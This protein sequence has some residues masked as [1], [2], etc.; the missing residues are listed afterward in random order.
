MAQ[1]IALVRRNYDD[2]PE[3]EFTPELLEAEA[4]RARELYGE[5]VY[6]QMWSRQDSPGAV[7]L[8]EAGSA[9]DARAALDTLPLT[10]KGM[11][12]IDSVIPLTPYRG[13]GPRG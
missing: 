1:F 13:F 5:G 4:E 9:D 8:I 6:R 3:A 7:I 12:L 11:L 10:Q 2:F